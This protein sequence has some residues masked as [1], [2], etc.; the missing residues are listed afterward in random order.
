MLHYGAKILLVHLKTHSNYIPTLDGWRAVAILLVLFE[1]ASFPIFSR[2]GWTCLGGHGVEIFFVI[3][4]YLITDRLL[5][6]DS[7]RR[8]YLRRAFR[9]LPLLMAYVIA[10][11]FFGFLLNKIPLTGSEVA[12]SLLFVR[13]YFDFPAMTQT[14]T[15]WFTAHFWS[16]SIEEQ[17]Y[18]LW[19]LIL[20]KIG[21]GVYRRQMFSVLVLFVL[22][23]GIVAFVHLGRLLH[24][25]GWHWLPNVKFGGLIVGCMVRVGFS[26]PTF[27]NAVRR[28]FAAR[29]SWFAVVLLAYIMIIHA[30]VTVFDPLFCGLGVCATLVESKSVM[31][32]ILEFPPLRWV[33][34]LS[35]SL[36]I[37][38][39]LFLG[40][41]LVFRP[42]G[43]FSRFPIALASLFFVSCLSYYLLERPMQRCGQVIATR[44]DWSFNRDRSSDVLA[45]AV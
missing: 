35:Y 3:S 10:V 25:G 27:G 6:E 33:G 21:K 29:G 43:W 5:H 8:F 1:H 7:L 14:G 31:G 36:Y 45:Q 18:L 2:V 20:L 16:L 32:R 41:G 17:F 4:G 24:W 34:R 15:G 42:M 22:G 30:R 23:S 28:I 40:F 37:W 38:Q 11:M 13:N 9:I 26:H 44:S 39:Q 19:P 12:A